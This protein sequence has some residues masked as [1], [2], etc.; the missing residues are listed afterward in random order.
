MKL[1]SVTG[2]L[3]SF[4]EVSCDDKKAESPVRHSTRRNVKSIFFHDTL[5]QNVIRM[6]ETRFLALITLLTL[7]LSCYMTVSRMTLT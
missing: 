4:N 1:D 6:I 2:V 7:F 5:S 3:N